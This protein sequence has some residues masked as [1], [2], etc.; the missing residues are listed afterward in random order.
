MILLK[1]FFKLLKQNFRLLE[2]PYTVLAVEYPLEDLYI[3]L[4]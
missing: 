4:G 2:D 1:Y 3:S